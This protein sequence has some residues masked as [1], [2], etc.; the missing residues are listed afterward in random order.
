MN[1]STPVADLFNIAEVVRIG[2]EE[3]AAWAEEHGFTRV[4]R[5]L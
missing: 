1:P 5:G 3:G 4:A 2:Y